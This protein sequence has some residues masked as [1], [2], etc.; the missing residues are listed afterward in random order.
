MMQL[1][2]Q[3]EKEVVF[4][5]WSAFLAYLHEEGYIA[6][7]QI[8]SDYLNELQTFY[9]E[10]KRRKDGYDYVFV[11][12]M[13]LFN[14]QERLVFHNLLTDGNAVP[15]VIMALDPKQ[16]PREVFAEISDDRDQRN[17]SIYER[18]QLP[19]PIKIDFV[20]VYRYTEEIAE[21][22]RTVLDAVPAL[23]VNDDWDL[24]GSSS[25][26]GHGPRPQY[27]VVADLNATFTTAIA[28]AKQLQGEARS[29][30]GQVAILCMDYDRFARLHPAA[31]GQNPK[32]VFVIASRDD[33]ERLRFMKQRIVFSTPE[34]VA[35]L[36]FDT[37]ILVDVNANLIPDGA[38]RGSAE[39][40]FLSELYLGM[41]RAE[42]RL[43]LLASRDADGLTPYLIAQSKNGLLEPVP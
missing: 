6:T 34:Y 23:D 17:R 5:L 3:T 29:N 14:A 35:G 9:W 33:V 32:D 37:V 19:N 11:D 18:A 42:R 7:D 15:K 38:Y 27:K 31:K 39:R 21:L 12:E 16:S 4:E 8:V 2:N 26:S 24:P 28:S 20:E 30:G 13:H 25:V 22:T 41:S 1:Q 36:Q 10:A 40:R 43:L